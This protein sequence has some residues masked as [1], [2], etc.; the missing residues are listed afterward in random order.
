MQEF[1]KVHIISVPTKNSHISSE[2][3]L[4]LRNWNGRFYQLGTGGYSGVLAFFSE[5]MIKSLERGN[6]VAMTD[7]GHRSQ[8]MINGKFQSINSDWA[9][10]QA[11]KIVDFGYRSLKKTSDVARIIIRMFYGKPPDYSY[12]S[13]CSGGGREALVAAHRYPDDWDGIIV[14]ALAN[15]F[16]RTVV[17]FSWQN[18]S[19]WREEGA[20]IPESM[21]PVIQAASLK[22]CKPEAYVINGIAADPRHCSLDIESLIC[23]DKAVSQ[24]LTERQAKSLSSLFSGFGE[25]RTGGIYSH[26]IESTLE[27]G[28]GWRFKLMYSD[29]TT[30]S[31]PEIFF[32]TMVFDDP[33]W[34]IGRLDFSQDVDAAESKIILG[35]S[36][37]EVLG[38]ALPDLNKFIFNG[39]KMIMYQGWG[40]VVIPPRDT[41]S[42][43]EK[44]TNSFST[45]HDVDDFI[46]L[47]MVPGM[48][49]CRGGAGANQFG[50][51]LTTLVSDEP[52][53]D[54]SKSLEAWVERGVVPNRIIATRFVDN[55]PDLGLEF[56]RPICPYPKLPVYTGKGDYNLHDNFYCMAGK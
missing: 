4:P 19:I 28:R 22:S 20:A 12:F 29:I 25:S 45:Q 1:C 38:P 17:H 30:R 7:G 23:K 10:H 55:N 43:F 33:D 9:L 41:I 6:A 53:H 49:H 2:I 51:P 31:L 56:T 37:T 35:E 24:C 8:V 26:G 47:F 3:W 48:S 44:V 27:S 18:R 21:L 36:L 50:Q 5:E 54:I 52:S 16:L 40:D 42:D 15:N 39:S 46:R 32:R 34:A 11:D 14:G 13:G